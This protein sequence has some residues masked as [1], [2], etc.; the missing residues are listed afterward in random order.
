[1]NEKPG[2]KRVP[3]G[4]SVKK[5]KRKKEKEKKERREGKGKKKRVMAGS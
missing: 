5:K 4:D 1:M 3:K 2:R